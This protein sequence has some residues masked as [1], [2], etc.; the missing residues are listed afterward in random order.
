MRNQRTHIVPAIAAGMLIGYGAK[1]AVRM[2]LPAEDTPPRKTRP[3]GDWTRSASGKPHAAK[4]TPAS[5]VVKA[6]AVTPAGPASAPAAAPA[7]AALEAA[8]Q[9]AQLVEACI[10]LADLT[11]DGNEALW[12][13]ITDALNAV[14]VATVIP[15]GGTFDTAQHDAVDRQPTPDPALHLTIASTDMPG[16]RDGKRWLRRPQVVVYRHQKDA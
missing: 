15:D 14:G 6:S 11:R 5:T 8:K 1:A 12:E 2:L 13:R 16:Y 3:A 7:P 10:G 9:R 4:G